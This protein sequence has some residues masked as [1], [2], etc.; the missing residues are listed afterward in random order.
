MQFAQH[1]I[2]N[3]KQ[4]N[5]QKHIENTSSHSY[6]FDITSILYLMF[7]C[8]YGTIRVPYLEKLFEPQFSRRTPCDA[9]ER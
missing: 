9:S 5:A 2:G 7:V 3:D 4:A 1:L 8:L 6:V